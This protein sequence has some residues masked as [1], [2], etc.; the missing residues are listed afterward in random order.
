MAASIGVP[1]EDVG[2]RVQEEVRLTGASKT[3]L[4]GTHVDDDRRDGK[5]S[6]VK[7]EMSKRGQHTEKVVDVSRA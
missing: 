7:P 4:K 1:G 6:F 3:H 2:F 5:K